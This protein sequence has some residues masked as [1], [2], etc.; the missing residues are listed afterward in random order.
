[1]QHKG[2]ITFCNLPSSVGGDSDIQKHACRKFEASFFP[3]VAPVFV[4]RCET[5]WSSDAEMGGATRH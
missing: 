3:D 4:E 2:G 5:K 1:L